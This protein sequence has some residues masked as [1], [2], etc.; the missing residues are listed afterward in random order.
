MA[1]TNKTRKILWGKSGNRCA[2]CKKELVVEATVHD[3][4]SVVGEEC[5]IVSSQPNGPRYDSNYPEESIESHENLILLCRTHHKMV[6]DQVATYTKDILLQMKANHLKW[7]SERLGEKEEVRKVR[8]RRTQKELPAFRLTSGN[9]V[10]QIV[11]GAMAYD[12]GHDNLLT[13]DEVELVGE[14]FQNLQD[15]GDIS[16]TLEAG[17]RVRVAYD[18]NNTLLTIEER[19]FHAFGAREVATLEGGQMGPSDWTIAIIRLIRQ[20]D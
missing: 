13:N 19:G 11:S 9:A 1:I 4:E 14:F 10:L 18:L 7:V 2:I 5:H 8:V 20:E 12:F 6:D 3:D 16:D 15:W 17:D